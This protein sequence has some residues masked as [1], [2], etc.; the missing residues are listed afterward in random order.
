E[1]AYY[2]WTGKCSSPP[3][4]QL[5][6]F[7]WERF[8]AAE[9][10]IAAMG[11]RGTFPAFR[12]CQTFDQWRQR[13]WNEIGRERMLNHT[14]EDGTTGSAVHTRRWGFSLPPQRRMEL[15]GQNDVPLAYT[16]TSWFNSMRTAMGMAVYQRHVGDGEGLKSTSQVVNLLVNAPGRDGAFK[17]FAAKHSDGTL[18]WAAGD[19]KL[20]TTERGYLGFDMAWTAYWMLRWKQLQLPGGERF[21]PVARDLGD[22]FVRHQT[23]SGMIPSK[24]KEDATPDL[25]QTQQRIAETA[26]IALFLITLAKETKEQK[27]QDAAKRALDF[28]SREV[29]PQGKWYDYETFYSCAPNWPSRQ[30]PNRQ[31]R[32]AINQPCEWSGQYPINNLCIG[33]T[34]Q[35]FLDFH[36]LTGDEESLRN[37]RQVLDHLLTFQQVWT[38]PRL[39][40]AG[41][42]GTLVGGFTTQNSDAEW[43]DARQSQFGNTILDY[44]RETGEPELLARGVAAIRSQFP[45]NPVENIAHTGTLGKIFDTGFHWGLGSGMAGVEFEHDFLGDLF[46]G[47][48]NKI[49]VG[50]DGV[51]VLSAAF[52]K[53][54]ATINVDVVLDPTRELD[55]KVVG[56]P[57]KIN[58]LRKTST[59]VSNS[60]NPTA[61]NIVFVMADDQGLGDLSIYNPNALV[62]TPNIDAL[63]ATGVRFTNA[64]STGAVCS[65]T[66]YSV[67]TG[68]YWW[69]DGKPAALHNGD[70]V[71]IDDDSITVPE[72]LRANGYKTVCV[73]KWHLGMDLAKRTESAETQAMGPAFEKLRE[74]DFTRPILNG[75]LQHGFDRYFGVYANVDIPV[76]YDAFIQDDRFQ[77]PEKIRKKPLANLKR[78]SGLG[79]LIANGFAR[80]GYVHDQWNPSKLNNRY[81]D[82][83]RSTIADHSSQPSGQPL[84]LHVVPNTIHTPYFPTDELDG[85]KIKGTT[86]YGDRG[87]VIKELDVMVGAIR[88][89]LQSK[90]MLENTLFVYTSDNGAQRTH[91]DTDYPQHSSSAKWSGH[92]GMILEGGHRVP[93]LC[94][95]PAGNLAAGKL[96]DAEVGLIDWIATVAKATN[97]RLPGSANHS[98]EFL[99][100]MQGDSTFTRPS[101]LIN[102]G[103]ARAVGTPYTPPFPIAPKRGH[104]HSINV[105]GTKVI[106]DQDKGPLYAF[107]LISDPTESRNV[108]D[109][110]CDTAA[111]AANAFRAVAAENR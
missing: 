54:Q 53:N 1:N 66:R 103:N 81:L 17:C 71:M 14:F 75:P 76:T 41:N 39:G 27:Y 87:D 59:R 111:M 94:S 55:V 99:L 65:A 32:K 84:Y 101:R 15:F 67:L 56:G 22:F 89:I 12:D 107:D 11:Q 68:R 110:A 96:I 91:F 70:P 51:D 28:L 38:N 8:G 24:Y 30:S 25:S 44:Y 63:A 109:D 62:P 18:R 35:A 86:Q 36:R 47:V 4:R 98:F 52:D 5:N 93:L 105:D 106:L 45:V 34:A 79:K 19:G 74:I 7:L 43:S 64:H 26:P 92:K 42:P 50:I 100:A 9:Q 37:G 82:F 78:E 95:W 61:P 57:A 108:L 49:A 33:H 72:F 3:L 10:K 20:F 90:G 23:D 16:F 80:G 48:E 97:S 83:I 58:V 13:V 2:V 88:Q 73:G 104:Y 46:V 31:K 29:I 40:Q 21:M 6:Q 77:S 102:T 85:V 69:N 60:S